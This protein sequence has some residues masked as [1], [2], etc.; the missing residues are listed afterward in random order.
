MSDKPESISTLLARREYDK[1]VPL[2]EVEFAKYP[3]NVRIHLQLADAL[4]GSGRYEDAAVEYAA[5]SKHYEES[6]L[7]VQAIAVRKKLEKVESLIEKSRAEAASA[8]PAFKD[9]IPKSPLFENMSE[10]ERE[11]VTR[12]MAIV[13]SV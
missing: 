9:P 6:G 1:A 5:T 11:A 3:T 10:E 4:A 7:T 8:E 12:G 2:L 13:L